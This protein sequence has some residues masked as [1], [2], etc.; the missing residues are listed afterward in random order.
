MLGGAIEPPPA[1][2]SMSS[3]VAIWIGSPLPRKKRFCRAASKPQVRQVPPPPRAVRRSP[4]QRKRS[5]SADDAL[6]LPGVAETTRRGAFE[7]RVLAGETLT[8]ADVDWTHRCYLSKVKTV[9]Q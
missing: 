5:G 4:C 6:R 8:S 1:P 9:H 7:R 2:I 3:I